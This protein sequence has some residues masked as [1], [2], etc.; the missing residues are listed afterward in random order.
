VVMRLLIYNKVV[1]DLKNLGLETEDLERFNRTIQRP[2]GLILT[3][4]PTG[5]GKTTTLYTALMT[6]NSPHIN[7]MTV[8]DPIEYVIPTIRQTAVNVKAGLT[9][10]NA[11]RSAM[12]QDPDVV[13]VGEIRDKVTADLAMRA[14]LTGHLVLSTLHTNDAASAI[15]RLL[16]L[17][18]NAS[19]L[20]SA[21][22]MIVAQRLVR[23]LCPRCAEREPITEAERSMFIGNGMEP[24]EE[25]AKPRGCDSCFQSGYRGRAGVYE[26]IQ[27]NRE[28]EKMIFSGALHREIEDVAMTAGTVLMFKQ[29]LKKVARHLTSLE[30]VQ[31]V[32]VD[33]A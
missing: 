15:N 9:F 13:L 27:V 33:Y 11:L 6:I 26:V 29:A 7:C 4:G 18:V 19:I 28:I 5:S 16:D 32:I 21:L 1:G 12:R 23:L 20:A 24:P 31:R 3:T 17:G 22:S 30:E 8:E 14:A 25:L 2:Y 10:E